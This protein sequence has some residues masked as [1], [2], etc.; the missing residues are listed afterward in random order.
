VSGGTWAIEPPAGA[1]GADVDAGGPDVEVADP[2][3]PPDPGQEVLDQPTSV[4]VPPMSK[5]RKSRK[6]ACSAAHAAPVTP[7]AGPDSSRVTGLAAATDAE[8]RPPSL[9]RMYSGPSTPPSA[10][11]F[12][13]L[14]T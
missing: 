13:R 4:L 11:C 10:S 14:S 8:A 7:P 3:L 6:P 1:D 2:G 5:V 9:R 12:A